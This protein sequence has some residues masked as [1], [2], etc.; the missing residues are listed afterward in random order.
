MPFHDLKAARFAFFR[1]AP[2]ED[3]PL[4]GQRVTIGY[5]DDIYLGGFADSCS[6]SG[7]E[8]PAQTPGCPSHPDGCLY[9]GV[10]IYYG[11]ADAIDT[12]TAI[13]LCDLGVCR[14]GFQCGIT[15][16]FLLGYQLE[17][18][19]LPGVLWPIRWGARGSVGIPDSYVFSHSE[20]RLVSGRGADPVALSGGLPTEPSRVSRIPST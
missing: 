7:S 5:Q 3:G 2:G 12:T 4:V 14:W 9:N 10:L 19:L 13:V 16:G 15:L 17:R 18:H 11:G 6:H 20:P 1:I 8:W